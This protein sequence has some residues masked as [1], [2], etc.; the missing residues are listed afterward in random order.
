MSVN[1]RMHETLE[2]PTDQLIARASAEIDVKDSAGRV[3][4]LKKPGLLAQYR[5]VEV[6]GV[7]AENPV[8]MSMCRPLIYIA[9]IDGDA[10]F[11]P[12]NKLQ[13]EA[14]I[15]RLDDHGL[16]AVV[17]G[18]VKHFGA[19]DPESEKATLKK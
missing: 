13:L 17:E 15:T 9:S 6:I 7:N 8:Y 14:L 2:T 5:L 16:E 3:F 11:Q 18:I 19:Q 12:T 1:V 10:I 4:K